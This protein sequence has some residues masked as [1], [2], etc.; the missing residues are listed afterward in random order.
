[1]AIASTP[2]SRYAAP[3]GATDNRVTSA[4]STTGT[5]TGTTSQTTDTQGSSDTASNQTTRNLDPASMA[6]LQ[7][8][9]KNLM[10]QTGQDRATKNQTIADTQQQQQ[11]FS[12]ANA[13]TDAQG[14]I[15]ET[16]RKALESTLPSIRMATENA[17][18]SGGALSA[19]LAQDAAQ[20]AAESGSALGVQTATNYGNVSANFAQVLSK[21][22]AEQTGS[23]QTIANA[24]NVLKGAV[25]NT[26]GSSSTNTS[27]SSTTNGTTQQ[28]TQ[29]NT[30]ERRDTDYAPFASS[31]PASTS[32]IYYG[33]TMDISKLSNDLLSQMSTT[34]AFDGLFV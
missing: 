3:G 27:Q 2:T 19:L 9:I 4:G 16:L 25:S 15:N 28:N 18:S 6:L 24:F 10:A 33:P 21:L 11:Q 20:R 12:K 13:F 32:P 5:S 30:Q 14:L 23:D 29:Q 26:T 8:F 31:S 1:M 7:G 34:R 22:L 17:G